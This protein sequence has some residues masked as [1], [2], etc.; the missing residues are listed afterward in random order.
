MCSQP[1]IIS[2]AESD[3]TKLYE[4][5]SKVLGKLLSARPVTGNDTSKDVVLQRM[6]S[7]SQSLIHVMAHG[8]SVGKSS[9]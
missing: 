3:P 9:R 1:L 6:T 5:G 8:V 7:G 4:V 2:Y